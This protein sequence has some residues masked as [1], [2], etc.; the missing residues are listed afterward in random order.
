M[1]FS[2]REAN[3]K[4]YEGLCNIFTEVDVFH[5]E[6]L[7][8]IFRE[9]DGPTRTKEF[10]SNIIADEN[11]ALF[12]AESN[13]QIIGVVHIVIR[14]SRD[15]PILVPRKYAVIDNLAVKKEYRRSGIGKSLV[16]KAQQWAMDKEIT[17]I[18][19]NVWEFNKGA[20]AFYE[21]LGYKTASRKMW[22]SL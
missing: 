17:Q 16:E 20:I 13:N 1:E 9:P 12:V 18:E 3:H 5:R 22:K 14:E 15:I 10:I 19:L 11:S 4:D 7:P 2:V 8:H 21:T 6:A